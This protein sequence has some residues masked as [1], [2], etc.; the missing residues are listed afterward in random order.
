MKIDSFEE[1][2][3]D[4]KRVLVVMAHPDDMELICGGTVA[5]LIATG[6]K[7]RSVVMTNGG[8]GMQN[9]IDVTENDFGKIRVGEQMAAGKVLGIPDDENFT[10]ETI[11]MRAWLLGT[12]YIHIQET[13]DSSRNI[14]GERV[15]RRILLIT[16]YL[17]MHI[18]TLA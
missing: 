12:Q 17:A 6:R 18:P 15:W 11:G 13:E 7:V 3:R 1:I 10:I 5:R 9:R 16:F 8:K 14:S 4:V 2:F